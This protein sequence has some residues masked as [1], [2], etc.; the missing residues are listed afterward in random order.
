MVAHIRQ[1][2]QCLLP[3]R[4]LFLLINKKRPMH[5]HRMMKLRNFK[6]RSRIRKNQKRMV[7]DVHT[8]MYL[9]HHVYCDSAA[10]IE[11]RRKELRRLKDQV[12][13]SKESKKNG[14]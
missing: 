4:D 13:D 3:C 5:V 12:K 9:D 6:I 8:Y 14:E 11:K 7:N 10:L 2:Y 1:K